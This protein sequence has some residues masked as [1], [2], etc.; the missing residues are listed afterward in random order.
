MKRRFLVYFALACAAT[1]AVSTSA[2]SKTVK[3]CK[4]DYKRLCPNTPIGR[5][6]LAT[7]IDKLSPACRAYIE[8]NK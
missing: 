3:E 4:A 6:D 5:C 7:M 1:I 8:K 2:E